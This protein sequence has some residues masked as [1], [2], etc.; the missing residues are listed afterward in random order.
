MNLTCK[1]G[2]PVR[3]HSD[4]FVVRKDGFPSGISQRHE[5][6]GDLFDAFYHRLGSRNR[7]SKEALSCDWCTETHVRGCE[8]VDEV[9]IG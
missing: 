2:N 7:A 5:L 9:H 1:H 6:W 3:G 4:T 8:K